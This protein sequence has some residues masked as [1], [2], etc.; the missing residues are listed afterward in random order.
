MEL[1]EV[2]RAGLQIMIG[3]LKTATQGTLPSDMCEQL[4]IIE[5]ELV[6]QFLAT[7]PIELR[8][9]VSTNTWTPWRAGETLYV[10]SGADLERACRWFMPPSVNVPTWESIEQS[11]CHSETWLSELIAAAEPVLNANDVALLDE[12][13]KMRATIDSPKSANTIFASLKWV[14]G[15]KRAFNRLKE[16]KYVKGIQK[17][18]GGYHLTEAGINRAKRLQ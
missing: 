3:A 8:L 10:G 5:A 12:M 14:T 1:I 15:G 16:F 17:P 7:I 4:D 11:A 9:S 6:R 18:G 13:L 2:W